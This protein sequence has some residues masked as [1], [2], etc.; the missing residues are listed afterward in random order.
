MACRPLPR[1][2]QQY[3]TQHPLGCGPTRRTKGVCQ[4]TFSVCT[5]IRSPPTKP[6]FIALFRVINRHVGNLPPML[7]ELRRLRR[8]KT[9][10]SINASAAS[11]FGL[12]KI[13]SMGDTK[14]RTRVIAYH[15]YI[16]APSN[17]GRAWRRTGR[18]STRRKAAWSHCRYSAAVETQ[19][20][21]TPRSS[22]PPQL[23]KLC[24]SA[25]RP[26]CHKFRSQITCERGCG[27]PAPPIH[28]KAM[29]VILTTDEERDVWMRAP[30]DEAKALQ[31][32]LPDEALRIVM[33]G[34]EKEDRE[35][36]IRRRLIRRCALPEL[37]ESR[38]RGSSGAPQS[39]R[40]VLASSAA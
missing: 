35:R 26:V 7:S 33:R 8:G 1:F 4:V 14:G 15:K 20:K 6:P 39:A 29:P 28:P 23:A 22:R 38:P 16:P 31:R 32:P 5:Y 24:A 10:T 3:R 2:G 34:A 30:W 36:K 27:A 37:R 17:R 25:C 19:E 12:I 18:Q 9:T 21:P 11:A 40:T 13:T